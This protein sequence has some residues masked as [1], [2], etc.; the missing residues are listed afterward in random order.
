MASS[1]FETTHFFEAD[2]V[3]SEI[4]FQGFYY[5]EITNDVT[6]GLLELIVF[7]C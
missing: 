7:G 1:C 2:S 4:G 5:S 3:S 6:K